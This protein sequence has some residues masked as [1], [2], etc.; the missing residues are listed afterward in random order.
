MEWASETISLHPKTLG[1]VG[2]R[3]LLWVCGKVAYRDIPP[4][5]ILRTWDAHRPQLDELLYC[6]SERVHP[7]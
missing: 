4:S 5:E 7:S 1:A 2:T 6:H 3:I